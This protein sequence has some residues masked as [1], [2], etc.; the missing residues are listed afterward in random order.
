[1]RGQ[2]RTR[3]DADED[4]EDGDGDRPWKRRSLEAR[5]DVL[6]GP[7]APPS[8]APAPLG[9]REGSSVV[10]VLGPDD[11]A[12][13]AAAD[14]AL[15][16]E[17]RD[18]FAHGYVPDGAGSVRHRRTG[19]LYPGQASAMPGN[20]LAQELEAYVRERLDANEDMQFA[21]RMSG[22]TLKPIEAYANRDTAASHMRALERQARQ[23]KE[24]ADERRRGVTPLRKE[25]D[26]VVVDL[27]RRLQQAAYVDAALRRPLAD[28]ARRAGV[29][30]WARIMPGA[31][32]AAAAEPDDGGMG[33]AAGLLAG[34]RMPYEW[35]AQYRMLA[36]EVLSTAIAQGTAPSDVLVAR[37]RDMVL[38]DRLLFAGWATS[39]A[40]RAR[41]DALFVAVDDA[42]VAWRR[43]KP[44]NWRIAVGLYILERDVWARTR[45]AND[46]GAE[47]TTTA[48]PT[49]LGRGGVAMLPIASQSRWLSAILLYH[50]RRAL[51]CLPANLGAN[52][53]GADM[54]RHADGTR[55]TSFVTLAQLP[56]VG[57]APGDFF[58]QAN[59]TVWDG[60]D[61][62][63]GD[64]PPPAPL[65]PDQGVAAAGIT[66]PCLCWSPPGALA[67]GN[68]APV[69]AVAG[70]RLLTRQL[71]PFLRLFGVRLTEAGGRAGAAAAAGAVPPSDVS[72]GLVPRLDGPADRRR[73]IARI[74]GPIPDVP[75]FS[76]WGGANGRN[77]F[78]SDADR[79]DAHGFRVDLATELAR[80]QR[81]LDRALPRGN[82]ADGFAAF[83]P[84]LA[85]YERVC[86]VLDAL[87][88]P[89]VAGLLN[90][91]AA[92][93][94]AGEE[95]KLFGFALEPQAGVISSVGALRG[96]L[97]EMGPTGAPSLVQRA[98]PTPATLRRLLT[99]WLVPVD[100]SPYA[101]IARPAD[102]TVDG[103]DVLYRAVVPNLTPNTGTDQWTVIDGRYPLWRVDARVWANLQAYTDGG[104]GGSQLAAYW[105]R[106]LGGDG[107]GGASF[108]VNA[109]FYWKLL[110]NDRGAT[111]A[112]SMTRYM[113]RDAVR[114]VASPASDA[115][116]AQRILFLGD[117]R[118]QVAG[119]EED[120]DDAE[121]EEDDANVY[122][123]L[124]LLLAPPP[125]PG[126]PAVEAE[127]QRQAVEWQRAD[128]ANEWLMALQHAR[129]YLLLRGTAVTAAS[130]GGEPYSLLWRDGDMDV[131]DAS[132]RR[133]RPGDRAWRRALLSRF[134]SYQRRYARPWATLAYLVDFLRWTWGTRTAHWQADVAR[135]RGI[136]NA[137][138]RRIAAINAGGGGDLDDGDGG[139][140]QAIWRLMRRDYVPTP[141][142]MSSPVLSRHIFFTGDFMAR[143]HEGLAFV[144]R[145]MSKPITLDEL[146]AVR[147]Y[148]ALA[149]AFLDYLAAREAYA[150]LSHPK[151]YQTKMAYNF[152]G[153]PLQQAER[154]LLHQV[155]IH[156]T[157]DAPAHDEDT[158][159]GPPVS[160]W[161]V[162]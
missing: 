135:L 130:D 6:L 151:A 36:D 118:E 108:L 1:M 56:Q 24:R 54:L 3:S 138:D 88:G 105:R 43:D 147:R 86:A 157:R 128:L 70:Q 81:L 85:C 32:A 69:M 140:G 18:A 154:E 21:M 61:T 16:D 145:W 153:V 137:L 126:P 92:V 93:G 90:I 133:R 51:D 150:L 12:D 25:R 103:A 148:P 58:A 121:E 156:G 75:L 63:P 127:R 29:G 114:P 97:A 66:Y 104:G 64:A 7:R 131:V 74:A 99:D 125:L 136:Q 30:T 5:M 11:G 152:I 8:L 129:P 94:A 89:R 14:D 112:D 23:E 100:V 37:V 55:V 161:F 96:V 149:E 77:A 122:S 15:A 80:P 13:A 124:P 83:Y 4:E 158:R 59:R 84:T 9:L 144:R 116:G 65:V 2:K 160:P 87:M 17:A 62:P 39:D 38:Y 72:L 57:M 82:A 19:A 45:L 159:H 91:V 78:P 71:D 132:D 119:E 48:V 76:A 107:A 20:P 52:G 33:A 31:E 106:A 50:T 123:P 146:T 73:Y 68:D 113:T 42:S 162:M 109:Q 49:T 111:M 27:T 98:E 35:V 34:M 79:A 115:A 143:I 155:A 67:D 134:V 40:V 60:I 41:T 101:R 141:E 26:N 10:R 46:V 28:F 44:E 47:L 110:L 95:T 117:R 102:G 142:Q 53:A 139:S 22:K 120:E